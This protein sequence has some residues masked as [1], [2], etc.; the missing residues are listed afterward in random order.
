MKLVL[1]NYRLPE[2]H[3]IVELSSHKRNTPYKELIVEDRKVWV[4]DR[5]YWVDSEKHKVHSNTLGAYQAYYIHVFEDYYYQ[6]NVTGLKGNNV[7]SVPQAVILK[8]HHINNK[9]E[10]FKRE[11]E[12]LTLKLS[13]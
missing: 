9:P 12:K 4:T 2:N 1:V 8:V 5:N 6:I 13:Y 3:A 10:F 7:N 11:I